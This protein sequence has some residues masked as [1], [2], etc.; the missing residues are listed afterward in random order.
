MG[1]IGK[2]VGGQ[3]EMQYFVKEGKYCKLQ[4]SIYCWIIMSQSFD[5][6]TM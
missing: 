6:L 1:L 2:F 3:A 5:E 4:R